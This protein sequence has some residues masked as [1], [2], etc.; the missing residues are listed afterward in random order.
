[1]D[2]IR[3]YGDW[4]LVIF[5]LSVGIWLLFQFGTGLMR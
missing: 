5:I 2:K 4:A 1:M 3:E